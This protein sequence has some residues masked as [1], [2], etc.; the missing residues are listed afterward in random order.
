MIRRVHITHVI[1]NISVL[2]ILKEVISIAQL[3]GMFSETFTCVFESILG[4]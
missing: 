1:A 2:G 3:C 4:A